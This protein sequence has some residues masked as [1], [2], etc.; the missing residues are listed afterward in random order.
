MPKLVSILLLLLC[1]AI[2]ANADTITVTVHEILLV[3]LANQ[4]PTQATAVFRPAEIDFV[5]PVSDIGVT[6][7]ALSD[8]SM[9]SF[10]TPNSQILIWNSSMK[11]VGCT[12]YQEHCSSTLYFGDSGVSGVGYLYGFPGL[13]FVAIDALTFTD[14]PIVTP[15]PGTLL[16][17]GIGTLV[18]VCA[19][20]KHA[21]A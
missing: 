3:P 20:R 8:F 17:L 5:T 6:W 1:V 12:W 9:A 18:L 7:Q 19:R 15:E 13:G 10:G 11:E 2:P 14:S 4:E 16:L 21:L